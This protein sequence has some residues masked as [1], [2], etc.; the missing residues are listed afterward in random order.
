MRSHISEDFMAAFNRG[1]DE[2]LAGN[3]PLAV[4]LLKSADK[5]M[6]QRVIEE[7]FA[8]QSFVDD[9]FQQSVADFNEDDERVSMGDGPSQ[10]IIK[11]IAD[12]GGEAPRNWKGYRPL[13]FK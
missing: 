10:R 5:I 1:R 12:M 4:R 6:F 13:N 9:K 8:G 3:W 2:Y 11:Y 7:G